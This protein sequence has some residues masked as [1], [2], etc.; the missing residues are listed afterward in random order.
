MKFTDG[1][2]W[3]IM[4]KI[5]KE[6]ISGVEMKKN[7]FISIIPGTLTL[8]FF[9]AVF[10]MANNK[11][12]AA[13]EAKTM[14][15]SLGS[16]LEMT[17]GYIMAGTTGKTIGAA[18]IYPDSTI[19]AEAYISLAGALAE[20]NITAFVVKY[21]LGL[22]FLESG[23]GTKIIKNN[24]QIKNWVIISHGD[25]GV[26]AGSKV[27]SKNPYVK[28]LVLMSSDPGD[29]S[30][31]DDDVEVVYLKGSAESITDAEVKTITD[32]LPLNTTQ[33]NIEGAGFLGF[34]SV[35][36]FDPEI[37]LIQQEATA[38]QAEK[39]ISGALINSSKNKNN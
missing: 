16:R 7:K 32:K 21:P 25:G 31:T 33:L 22:K 5:K 35:K 23:T 2:H 15:A 6:G 14:Q 17:S 39:I 18:I 26:K 3:T 38:A 28:G 24:I 36:G 30:L 11:L 19:S 1:K 37:S 29:V 4:R 20:R 8:I 27:D 13:D 10:G 9:L 34:A 12:Q